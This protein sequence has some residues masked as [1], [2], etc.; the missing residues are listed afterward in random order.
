MPYPH[1]LSPYEDRADFTLTSR[2]AMAPMTRNRA[3]VSLTPDA[4][5][6]EYYAQRAEAGMLIT[7]A[8]IVA[9]NA[10]GYQE[11]PGFYSDA[12]QEGWAGVIDAVR[13]NGDAK[14][15]VQLFHCGRVA[16][17]SFF[18]DVPIAPS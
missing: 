14:F 16:H 18:G 17:P 1:L 10:Q 12:Q 13:R 9:P 15:V 8:T 6:A 4:M 3:G 2:L 7:E 5:N 11:I